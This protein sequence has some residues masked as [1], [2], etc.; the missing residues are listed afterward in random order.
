MFQYRTASSDQGFLDTVSDE[1]PTETIEGDPIELPPSAPSPLPVVE[2]PSSEESLRAA[3]P[4]KKSDPFEP[5]PI[6]SYTRIFDGSDDKLGGN[7]A[8]LR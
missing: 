8:R 3:T 2:S 5:K 1:K 7:F 4:L 6:M